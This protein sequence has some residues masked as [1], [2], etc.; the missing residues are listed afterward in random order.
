MVRSFYNYTGDRT[1]VSSV[2]SAERWATR[3]IEATTV[4]AG[5]AYRCASEPMSSSARAWRGLAERV[6]PADGS[7]GLS[8]A[9]PGW[10]YPRDQHRYTRLVQLVPH[11]GPGR[12]LAR[13]KLDDTAEADFRPR[14]LYCRPPPPPAPP[15][16]LRASL[17]P[18][19][20][21][22]IGICSPI[23]AHGL[24]VP[25][26]GSPVPAEASSSAGE[27]TA[28]AAA[29]G[30]DEPWPRPEEAA[31]HQLHPWRLPQQFLRPDHY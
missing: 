22:T 2:S 15:P 14:R 17:P 4:R 21:S 26:A 11:F 30:E 6:L 13:Y 5:P 28:T 23:D 7:R 10:Y 16:S 12:G 19:P 18:R 20:K 3:P 8:G 1:A 31:I 24:I 27:P 25:V 29:A 9:Q